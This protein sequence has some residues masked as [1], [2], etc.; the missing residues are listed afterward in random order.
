[1]SNVFDPIEFLRDHNPVPPGVLR[2]T[3]ARQAEELLARLRAD[4]IGVRRIQAPHRRRGY[5]VAAAL[6]VAGAA[7]AASG[8][9]LSQ[10][11][12]RSQSPPLEVGSEGPPPDFTGNP[13]ALSM[14][15]ASAAAADAALPFKVVLPSNATPTGM[16]VTIPAKTPELS[17]QVVADFDTPADGIYQLTEQ[18]SNM[19]VDQLRYWSQNCTTCTI[20]KLV[21]VDAVHVL[22]LAT[23]DRALGV[24]WVRGDGRMPVLTQV[25]GPYGKFAEQSALS[26]AGD[27]ISR[28]G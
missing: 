12:Q 26:I 23:P 21:I 4:E 27:I 6:V 1:M 7:A 10:G 25:I 22:V 24:Y 17:R 9:L 28:Q 20:Q 2:E 18:V 3:A 15:A 8:L 14:P 11:G 5:L 16:W 19:T 13:L